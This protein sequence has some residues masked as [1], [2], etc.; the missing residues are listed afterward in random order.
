MVYGSPPEEIDPRAPPPKGK[1]VRSSSFVDA[2]LMHD[3]VTGRSATGIIE[4]LN[5]TP[6][7]WLSKR[8]SQVETAIYGSEFMAAHTAVER[9]IDLQCTLCS[10]GVPLDGCA[11]LFGDNQL[12]VTSSTVPHST[13]GKHWNAL[14]H[15]RAREAIAGKWLRF[16]HISGLRN[17]A[18][19]MTKCLP[20]YFLHV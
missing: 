20:W 2:N 16:E 4:L 13:L 14:S 3:L 12:V 10:F 1:M 18:D 17:P 19:M 7:D 9:L 5:Q 6:I 11:W 8:Q 15:H